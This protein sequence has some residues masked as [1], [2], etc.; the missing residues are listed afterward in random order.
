MMLTRRGLLGT[1]LLGAAAVG[2]SA[3]GTNSGGGTTADGKTALRLGWWG[4]P[5]RNQNTTD[6]IA[7]YQTANTNVAITPEVGDWASYWDKLATQMAANDAPDIIQM[8][9]AYIREYGA[10]G[11]LADLSKNVDTAKFAPGTADAGKL[12]KG[13]MGINAGVNSLTLLAN[14]K[15]FKQAGVDLPDDSTWTWDGLLEVAA[16]VTKGSG[17]K[18]SGLSG[19]LA[20]DDLIGFWLRQNG[21]SFYTEQGFGFEPADL[22]PYF[23]W[24]K[25]MYDSTAS[26]SASAVVEDGAKAVDQ[27]M[28]ATGKVAM[29]MHWSNQVKALD[30]ASGE[31]LKLLQMPTLAGDAAQGA[32][33]YKASMLWSV[34]AR[35]KNV[36]AAA[37]MIDFIVND[38]AA[39]KIIKAERGMPAN[40]DMRKL[41]END[42]DPSDKKALDFL[43]KIEPGIKDSPIPPLVGT[44][45]VRT[46]LT[47]VTTDLAFGR[48]TPEAAAQKFY[49][50]G[51]GQIQI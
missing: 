44:A 32:F 51:K 12:P 30:A 34:N 23:T 2:L 17:G 11:A 35:S 27:Q 15:L 24:V 46:A 16:A 7:A 40:L 10:R 38:A 36:D 4:N 6:V 18:F 48:T 26:P 3:C 5:T 37:A 19:A 39:A 8:D 33:W 14:E 22:V 20:G 50:D 49:D 42:L 1:A 47:T 29:A 25:K 41:I 43:N 21:K 28:L 9:M 45:G 13:L 31:D